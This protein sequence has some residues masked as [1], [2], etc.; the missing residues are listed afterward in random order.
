MGLAQC[1]E[2]ARR[3]LFIH[4]APGGDSDQVRFCK[5]VEA[6][7]GVDRKTGGGAQ[8]GPFR[9]AYREVVSRQAVTGSVQPEHLTDDGELE[10]GHAVASDRHHVA[11][12]P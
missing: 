6:K 2:Q 3:R 11:E 10:C 7:G 12:H 4:V 8:R 1:F 5:P 9:R